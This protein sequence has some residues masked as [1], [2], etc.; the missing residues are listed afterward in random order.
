[1]AG[2]FDRYLG[3]AW[4]NET[5]SPDSWRGIDRIPNSELWRT[6]ERRRERLVAFARRRLREQLVERG[7]SQHEII[8]ADEVL[9]PEALTIGFARRFATYKRA[10]LLFHDRERL[11]RLLTDPDRPIQI[12]FAGKAHPHDD[13]GKEL[14]REIVH[15]ARQHDVRH[16]IVFLENYNMNVA[17]YLVQGVDV[18]LNTPRRPMEASGT[19][20]MKVAANGG[21]N[22]SILDGWWAEA[23]T[24]EVGWAIGQGEEYTDPAYQDDIE[25]HALYA[26]LEEAVIPMFYARGRDHLPREWIAMMKASLRTLVPYF[27][28]DRMLREYC[29]KFYLPAKDHYEHLAAN[30]F[31]L[32]RTMSEW[33]RHVSRNWSEVSIESA[34]PDRELRSGLIVGDEVNVSAVV[35]LGALRPEDV[36]VEM[37]VGP[38]DEYRRIRN[39]QAVEMHAAE[40]SDNGRFRY[41]GTYTCQA[42][43][44]HGLGL[45]IIPYHELLATKYEMGRLLWA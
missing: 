1:M 19:S 31:E 23:Y 32:A 12:I 42:T 37:Y 18:W 16:R 15:F 20:G 26:L 28:T 9:D 40:A 35:H 38:L 3:S 39:G 45:R 27:S 43:G 7:A 8:D 14:I 29:E 22:L 36:L 25:A 2:L 44:N 5:S 17:R 11:R 34:A 10:T 4:I 33:R 13:S 6:H 30:S 21:L 41:S 24:P